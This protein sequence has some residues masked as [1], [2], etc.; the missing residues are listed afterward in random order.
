MMNQHQPEDQYFA[1]KN[2]LSGDVPLPRKK[3]NKLAG[4][5]LLIRYK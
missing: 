5:Y 3:S 4:P 2:E 1:E